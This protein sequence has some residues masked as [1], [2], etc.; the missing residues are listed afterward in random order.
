M[1]YGFGAHSSKEEI[2][3]GYEIIDYNEVV[4]RTLEIG[5]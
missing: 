4:K 3:P 1:A 5:R 2:T